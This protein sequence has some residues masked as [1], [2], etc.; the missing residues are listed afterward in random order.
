M[1]TGTS[2]QKN[3]CQKKKDGGHPEVVEVSIRPAQPEMKNDVIERRMFMLAGTGKEKG[4]GSSYRIYRGAQDLG[5]VVNE[6]YGLIGGNKSN[7]Q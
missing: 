2:Q 3:T 1:P 4:K 6:R 7:A 5:L